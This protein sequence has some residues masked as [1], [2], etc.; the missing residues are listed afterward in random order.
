ML[1]ATPITFGTSASPTPHMVH[2]APHGGELGMGQELHIEI[3]SERA[4]QYKVYL[5]DPSGKPIPT[6]GNQVEVAIIDTSGKK[7]SSFPASAVGSEY[8]VAAGVETNSAKTDVRVTVMLKGKSQPVEMDFTIEYKGATWATAT[9]FV[10]ATL[11]APVALPAVTVAP[12]RLPAVHWLVTQNDITVKM[13][14]DP[15]PPRLGT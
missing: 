10:R 14:F 9:P 1:S 12:G 3:L 4:A 8:F 6:E 15:Y 7:L 2:N 13:F 5:Y 11:T